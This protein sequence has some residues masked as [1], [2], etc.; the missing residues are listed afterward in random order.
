MVEK[1]RKRKSNRKKR[2]KSP[3][4]KGFKKH[5]RRRK[6]EIKKIADPQKQAEERKKFNELIQEIYK[7]FGNFQKSES[8]S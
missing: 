1:R 5:I 2:K 3:F 8:T 7:R 6:S 4:S